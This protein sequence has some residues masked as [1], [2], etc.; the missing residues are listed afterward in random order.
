[1]ITPEL[2]SMSPDSSIHSARIVFSLSGLHSLESGALLPAMPLIAFPKQVCLSV[3]RM[4]SVTFRRQ[5][6][7]V[8]PLA[9]VTYT[10]SPY[11][12]LRHL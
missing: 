9:G 4:G 10:S 1:M 12:Y 2:A 7:P 6:R 11:K 8:Q 5:T 3:V